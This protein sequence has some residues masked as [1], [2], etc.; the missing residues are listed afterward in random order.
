MLGRARQRVVL[1]D[2]SKLGQASRIQICPTAEVDVLVTDA[3][4]DARVLESLAAAGVKRVLGG[5]AA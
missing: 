4:A 3:E 1:A 5:A 2:A